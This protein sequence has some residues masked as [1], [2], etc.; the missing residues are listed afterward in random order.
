MDKMD[1]EGNISKKD[2]ELFLITDSLEDAI[3]MV[4]EKCI[5][6]FKLREEKKFRPVKWLF[7]KRFKKQA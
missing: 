5:K 2:R 3:A 6:K 7:E 1:K 4:N